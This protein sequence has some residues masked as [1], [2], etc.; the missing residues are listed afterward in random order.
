MKFGLLTVPGLLLVA[1]LS[2][3][4]PEAAKPLTAEKLYEAG[5]ELFEQFAQTNS[6]QSLEFPSRDQWNGFVARLQSA[7]NNNRL[8][9]L[10]AYEPQARTVLAAF[11]V[12]PG[13]EDYVD[14]LK[15]RLDS[16]DNAKR[17]YRYSGVTG[18]SAS[19]YTGILE[20]A[21]KGSGSTVTWR[22][23]Y[24]SD[25]QPTII[26]RTIVATLQKVGLESLTKR[27]G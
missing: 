11:Q 26:I 27:L 15:E 19:N 9:E 16:T 21:P 23:Q 5:S 24:L 3:G 25:G 4:E 22:V 20:V 6:A 1:G 7:L 17:Q 12:L 18:M 2:A 14:W 8:D 10:A 13:Y